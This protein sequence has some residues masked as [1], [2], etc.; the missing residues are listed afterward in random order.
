MTDEITWRVRVNPRAQVPRLSRR[1]IDHLWEAMDGVVQESL[2][3]GR[4]PPA[5]C[6]LTAVRDAREPHCPRCDA[7]LRKT[8][9]AGRTRA[10]C[11]RCQRR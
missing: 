3:T 5:D 9:V 6:W 2:P 10:W 8:T 1:R 11:P 7:R 4:V